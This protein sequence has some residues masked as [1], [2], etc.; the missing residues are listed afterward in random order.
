MERADLVLFIRYCHGSEFQVSALLGFFFFFLMPL[1]LLMECLNG[2]DFV[3]G[4]LRDDRKIAVKVL[5]IE[6][7]SMRGERE[8]IAELTSL[9]NIRHENLVELKGFYVDGSNRYLVYDYMENNSLAYVL[10]GN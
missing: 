3:K 1:R 5:S 9:S 8:F 6:V 2:V 7:E 4:W 10:Q